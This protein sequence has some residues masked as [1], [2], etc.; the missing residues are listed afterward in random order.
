MYAPVLDADIDATVYGV[1][2]AKFFPIVQSGDWM[3]E[4]PQQND[5]EMHNVF[6]T[7]IDGSY[8]FFCT[9]RRLAGF[10]LHTQQA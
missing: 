8:Q 1:N 4:S 6:V 2:H 10:A 9:N 5:V 7:F 3:R